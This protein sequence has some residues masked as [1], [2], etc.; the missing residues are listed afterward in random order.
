MLTKAGKAKQHDLSVFTRL[1]NGAPAFALPVERGIPVPD[2]A[3]FSTLK[4]PHLPT[5]LPPTTTRFLPPP[6][7]P[8]LEYRT[9]SKLQTA[10]LNHTFLKLH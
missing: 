4:A 3:A 1:R 8:R 9:N 10:W 7:S 2:G 5:Q 6:V